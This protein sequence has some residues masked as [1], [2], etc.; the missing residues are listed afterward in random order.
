MHSALTFGIAPIFLASRVLYW[1]YN[2]YSFSVLNNMCNVDTSDERQPF[3]TVN[4]HVS[5][6]SLLLL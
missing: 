3:N 4:L 1:Y 5:K 2:G 6:W